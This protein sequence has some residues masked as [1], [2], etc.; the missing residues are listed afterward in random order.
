MPRVRAVALSIVAS[1]W[2]VLL[3]GLLVAARA[4]TTPMPAIGLSVA[5]GPSADCPDAASI[6]AETAR[7]LGHDPFVPHHTSPSVRIAFDTTSDGFGARIVF[8]GTP[9]FSGRRVL[10]ATAARCAALAEPLGL[11]LAVALDEAVARSALGPARRASEAPAARARAA[12]D[13]LD[14]KG[15]PAPPSRPWRIRLGPSI[16]A[17]AFDTPRI[18]L[19]SG[20]DLH[21]SRGAFA[22]DAHVGLAHSLPAANAPTALTLSAHALACLS[23]GGFDACA[24]IRAGFHRFASSGLTPIDPPAIAPHIAPTLAF[25][26]A[27][28]LGPVDLRPTFSVALPLVRSRVA[29]DGTALWTAPPLVA[30][31]HIAVLFPLGPSDESDP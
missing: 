19:G 28:D 23:L 21:L 5:P 14:P 20:F 31:L 13:G 30:A 6:A 24:G 3:P 10:P 18:A 27:I 15:Q 1:A 7:A 2:F 4:A 29:A 11:I 26:A 12:L 22:L 9:T 8:S 17:R 16:V 25:G